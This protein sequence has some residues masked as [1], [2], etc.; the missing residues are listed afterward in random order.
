MNLKNLINV[1]NNDILMCLTAKEGD[2]VKRYDFSE[3][4]WLTETAIVPSK[5]IT[6]GEFFHTAL[7]H[8][9]KNNK[10][11]TWN[12]VDVHNIKTLM[13][14][15]E[16]INPPRGLIL[17]ITIEM[18]NRFSREG[19]RYMEKRRRGFTSEVEK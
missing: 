10:L 2:T 5:L 3:G 9:V 16:N 12:T 1:V 15:D 6:V 7:Y 8:N 17:N 11:I 13:E 19:K 18:V 14:V 4:R